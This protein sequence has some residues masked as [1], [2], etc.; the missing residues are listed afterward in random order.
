MTQ[1]ECPAVV[2]D[3]ESAPFIG[4]APG[5]VDIPGSES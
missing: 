1:A 4:N 3:D 5:I 2:H